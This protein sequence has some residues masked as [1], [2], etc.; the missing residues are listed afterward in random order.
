MT[1]R[2]SI[3]EI[4]SRYLSLR[5]SGNEF[6]G[7]CPFHA[8]KTPSFSVNAGKGVFHCFGCGVGGDVFSFIMAIEK[9]D[10]RGALAHLGIE[11]NSIP[12]P[13][14]LDDCRRTGITIATWV[15]EMSEG[16]QETLRGVGQRQRIAT[17]LGWR[18]EVERTEREWDILS[19]LDDD[20]F[21]SKF[22]LE[23][24]RERVGVGRLI[25]EVTGV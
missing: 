2:P 22:T 25:D 21:N 8:E 1:E 13:R 7:L 9:T 17:K 11:P 3:V 14:M 23:I 5:R 6:S 10:F 15:R 4:I 20:L 16:L 18:D 12:R 24:Y 19:D